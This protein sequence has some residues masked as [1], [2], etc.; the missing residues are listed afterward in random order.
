[1]KTRL[2]LFA[3]FVLLLLPTLARTDAAAAPLGLAFS[4]LSTSLLCNGVN[5]PYC[6]PGGSCQDP[7]CY[8]ECRAAGGGPGPCSFECC[9]GH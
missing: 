1:M 3:L 5:Y 4:P 6:N 8:C 7:C 2:L 9:L